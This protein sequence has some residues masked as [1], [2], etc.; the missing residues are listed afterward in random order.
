MACLLVLSSVRLYRGMYELDASPPGTDGSA[1]V[2]DALTD[3]SFDYNCLVLQPTR[4]T[5]GQYERIGV[6]S[7]KVISCKIF[8]CLGKDESQLS[9][10][11]YIDRDEDQGFVIELV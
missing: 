3:V 5:P 8:L 9:S 2:P 1:S 11:L 6:I 7:H 4:I 10:E